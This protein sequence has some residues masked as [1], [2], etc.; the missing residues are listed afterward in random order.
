[1]LNVLAPVPPFSMD[2]SR[3]MRGLHDLHDLHE[4]GQIARYARSDQNA[5]PKCTSVTQIFAR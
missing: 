2:R 1:M 3:D 5:A 4:K